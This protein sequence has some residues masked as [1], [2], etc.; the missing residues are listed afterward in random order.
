M[1]Q[2]INSGR[3]AVVFAMAIL[4]LA[5]PVMAKSINKRA[6]TTGFSFLKLG[7][8]A[9]AVAMGGAFTA[10]ADDPT[11]MYYNPAGL[12]DQQGRQ[13]LAGYH[14][15]VLDM[16]SGYVAYTTSLKDSHRIGMF[17]DYLN[18]GDFTRT[19]VN[20]VPMDK[21]SGGDF[22]IGASF[23]TR[24]TP[25]LSGGFNIK[26]MHEA[27][28]TYGSDAFAVDL[29]LRMKMRDS[30]TTV[31]LSFF[32]LGGV[33]S[34]YTDH[35]DKLPMGVRGGVSHSLR[36]LPLVIAIDGV[37]PNDNDPYINVGT[38]FYKFQPLYLRLGYSLFGENYKTG[39]DSDAW[40]G[41]AAGF[42]L[43]F[44]EYH[45]AYAFMPYLDLGSSHRVT[46][47]GGF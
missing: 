43:D 23:A 38:E 44:K 6:G 18:F 37:L 20:G 42:G 31:G 16:Q 4:I 24:L 14:N 32:N 10:L 46:I 35:K 5:A 19:D 8:G 28:D 27:A 7:V 1:K 39:S 36:E 29:G 26:Y 15:Y 12:A 41:F 22:L 40:G 13:F 3:K 45:I 2:N 17:I 47:S 11:A 21:F 34:G 9:K 25:A 33:F 30:L